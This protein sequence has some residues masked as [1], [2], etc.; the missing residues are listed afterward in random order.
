M[1]RDVEPSLNYQSS[2]VFTCPHCG[3]LATHH[4]GG[5]CFHPQVEVTP[6][7]TD[8]AALN[9]LYKLAC[10]AC[11]LHTI[12]FERKLV[13]P[14]PVIGP[15]AIEGMPEDVRADYEEARTVANASPSSQKRR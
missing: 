10:S 3:V 4:G 11:N 14:H 13:H 15:L 8:A 2:V 7:T 12:F 5:I 1:S 9:G 6:K